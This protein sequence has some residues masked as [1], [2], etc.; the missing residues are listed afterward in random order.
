MG[1]GPIPESYK[2]LIKN[3]IDILFGNN[4]EFSSMVNSNNIEDG[5]AYAKSLDIFMVGCGALG[6]E[7]SKNLGMLEACSAVNSMLTITDMD[8]IELSNLNRQF[9][10]RGDNIGEHKSTTV[11][12]RLGEYFPKMNVKAFTHEVSKGTENIFNTRFWK[13]NTL[14]VNALDNVE[15]RKYVDSKCVLHEKPLFESGT[16]GSKCNTQTIIPKKTATYSEIIDVDDTSI[17]MCTIRNF[18][19]KIEHCIEWGLELFENIITK[20]L[21]DMDKFINAKA[22]LKEELDN[23]G[24]NYLVFTK[25]NI[26]S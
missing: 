20:S 7:L 3:N 4:D 26:R 11:K 1:A 24:N 9:L 2:S 25:T 13:N 21:Q 19:N 5:I 6:C 8:T 22:S 10:F 18:P 14:I 16:L 12:S 23:L 17:P 15:A